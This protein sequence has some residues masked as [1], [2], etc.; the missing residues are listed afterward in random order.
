MVDYVWG[1]G[2]R[3]RER[4]GQPPWACVGTGMDG[5]ALLADKGCMQLEGLQFIHS[6]FEVA[7]HSEIGTGV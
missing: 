6:E 3:E 1:Q 5:A 4:S 2:V 7:E